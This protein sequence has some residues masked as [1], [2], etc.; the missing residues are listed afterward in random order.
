VVTEQHRN[1]AGAA[2]HRDGRRLAAC[3]ICRLKSSCLPDHIHNDAAAQALSGLIVPG[4]PLP[5]GAYLYR[6]GE[7]RRAYYLLRT[8]SA[9]SFQIDE[10]GQEDVMGFHFPTDMLGGASLERRDYNESVVVL[11]RSTL[12]EVPAA[13]LEA[14]LR[15]DESLLHS[16]FA[17]LAQSFDAER[18]ARVRLHHAS[19]DQR[20]ADFLLELS[21]RFRLVGR[22]DDSLFLSMSRHDIANYLGLAA[23]TVSRALGRLQDLGAIAVKGKSVDIRARPVLREIAERSA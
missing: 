11:E 20:V 17:K 14:L 1:T 4:L 6:Q 2:H 19:A 22:A 5:R 7:P 21:E 13:E 15:G 16:F 12:C 10:H 23:E 9:K 18:H 3:N 8:G